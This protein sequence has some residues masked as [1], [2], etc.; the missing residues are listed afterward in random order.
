MLVGEGEG[1]DAGESVG[2]ELWRSDE[3][4]QCASTD[5]KQQAGGAVWRNYGAKLTYLVNV[6]VSDFE[7]EC[8][9]ESS[10]VNLTSKFPRCPG[11]FREQS[12]EE[13]RVESGA[14]D[15]RQD[16]YSSRTP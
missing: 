16:S 14:G 10:R 2:V 6:L 9:T 5:N 11:Y 1:E 3:A 13:E 8:R 4:S 15:D 7:I 12:H